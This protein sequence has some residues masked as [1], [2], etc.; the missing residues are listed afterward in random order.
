MQTIPK[1]LCFLS[2]L[3]L[4]SCG[5][6]EANLPTPTPTPEEPIVTPTTPTSGNEQYLNEKSSYIFDQKKLS[7][8]ELNLPPADLAKIDADPSAEEYVAGSLTFEGETISQ[9]G[10][11]YKGSIGAYVGCL[12]G[13]D[14]ANPSGRKT[15]TKLSMKIKINWNDSE[16]RFYG[17]KKLQFHSQ[18]HDDSQMR[19]RLGYWFFRKMDVPAPRAIH[20]RLLVNG[21][22]MG[23]FALIEQIDGRF[24][25]QNF[26]DGTGNLYKEIWPLRSNGNP[27]SEQEYLENL[28]TNKDENPNA[29]MIRSFCARSSQCQ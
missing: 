15:C 13:T 5:G 16:A 23:L 18:N 3:L 27:F 17:L 22:Y 24:T 28:K 19:D 10:I 26:E 11:R 9:V 4:F 2:I 25:R 12:S 14:W 20:A 7:T 1:T 6:E 29:A 21:K 8:F